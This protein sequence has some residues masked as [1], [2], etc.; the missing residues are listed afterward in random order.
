MCTVSVGPVVGSHA[1]KHRHTAVEIST[2]RGPVIALFGF[3]A[4]CAAATI[5]G[6]A[7][8]PDAATVDDLRGQAMFAAPGVSFVE[9]EAIAVQPAC[10][11]TG[12][13]E[14][15]GPPQD[16]PAECGNVN[17]RLTE[18]PERGAVEVVDVRAP[19][20][21]AGLK[22]GDTVRLVRNETAE[23]PVIYTFDG[24]NRMP[25]LWLM[26]GLFVLSVFLV[27]RLRRLLALVGLGFGGLVLLKFMLPALLFRLL[28]PG[29]GAHR[30]GGHHVRGA[31]PGPRG[32]V[33]T[34]TALAGTLV[35]VGLIAAAGEW[36]VHAA[37]LTGLSDEGSLLS[38]FAVDLSFQGLLTCALIVGR[39]WVSSTT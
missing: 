21:R 10:P 30:L 39:A 5:V 8:W 9:A 26:T 25:T 12:T 11:P 35:G 32:V 18:G 13:D 29:R 7:L 19:V 22:P 6:V 28:R 14:S 36:A 3:L 16:T 34:S 17:A 33:R 38:A 31:V 15:G 4:A 2:A 23:G 1:H 37:R 20:V 24:V 27:A